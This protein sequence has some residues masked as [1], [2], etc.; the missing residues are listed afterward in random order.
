[1]VG[2]PVTGQVLLDDGTGTYPFD[3]TSLVELQEGVTVSSYGRTDEFS[4]AQA[5][6]LTLTIDNSDGSLTVDSGFDTLPFGFGPFG[7]GD[8]GMIYPTQGIRLKLTSG[9][10]T[11]TRF[12]GRITALGAG[13]PGGGDEYATVQITAVDV[14]A[15][16]ARRTL[17]SMLEEEILLSGPTAFYTL[18]EAEGSTS[19]GDTSGSELPPLTITG[20]GTA[21]TFGTGTGPGTDGLTA[22]QF[23][24]GQYLSLKDQVFVPT[25]AAAFMLR[26]EIAAT[27]GTGE[28]FVALDDQ[29]GTGNAVGRMAIGV[30]P[31][32]QLFGECNGVTL[33]SSAVV[34]D[35]ANHDGAISVNGLTV[36][37]WLD[38]AVVATGA[39]SSPIPHPYSRLGVG[40][41]DIDAGA[42]AIG[43]LS[44]VAIYQTEPP[45]ARMAAQRQAASGT[46]ETITARLARIASYAGAS[47][48]TTTGMSSQTL[49][50]QA[51]SGS[52]A[53]DALQKVAAAE[54]GVL[55]ARGDGTVILQGRNYRAQNLAVDITVTAEA[56]AGDT[57]IPYDTQQMFNRV[58]VTSGTGATQEVRAPTWTRDNDYPT[59][60]DVPVPDSDALGAAQWLAGSHQLPSRRLASATFD[61]GSM[62][63][64]TTGADGEDMLA[65]EVGDRVAISPMPSQAWESTSDVTLEGWAE[66]VTDEEWKLTANLL[67]WSLFTTFILDNATYGV[68]DG[69]T[70]IGY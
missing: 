25:S 48:A 18:G 33:A 61:L 47:T 37:L 19:A 31:T 36:S 55:Y 57:A 21:L 50:A 1:M 60:L 53:L 17:R 11:K 59:D 28:Y 15:D 67:P 24:G 7:G 52:S 8:G 51:T 22:T 30:N 14:L 26:A 38:G 34:T 58:T 32:G 54:G 44:H 63:V 68:L 12:T 10:T 62:T 29:A 16:L 39:M 64:A 42:H 20:N 43:T 27:G 13:W 4:E 69:S 6:Q 46:S 65:L 9:A 41:T 2:L 49:S 23:F 5:A 40:G 66:T 35:G 45:A 3:V 56:I 70:P